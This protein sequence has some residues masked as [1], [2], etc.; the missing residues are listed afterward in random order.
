MKK[1]NAAIVCVTLALASPGWAGDGNLSPA[2]RSLVD[3]ER[4]F[5][6]R[7]GEVGVRASF[8]QFFADDAI[9]FSPE[10][11]R[12]KEA[13]KDL[14]PPADPLAVRLEWEPQEGSVASS[15]DLGYDT[16]PS[17]LTNKS[18][19]DKPKRFGQF[20]SVWKR[21]PDGSWKV[22]V[23]IGISTPA[24]A[25]PFGTPFHESAGAE[26]LRQ[27]EEESSSRPAQDP[28]MLDRQLTELS[29]SKGTLGAYLS[30]ASGEIRLLRDNHMPMVGTEGLRLYLSG[31]GASW[32]PVAGEI[33][34]AGDLGYTYGSYNSGP[35][36]SGN[37]EKGY[38]V[39]VCKRNVHGEWKLVADITNPVSPDQKK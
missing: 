23:D 6:K 17:V 19:T 27:R 39:H 9:A 8:L 22:A 5:A 3:T 30:Q 21:Q 4:S 2:L 25:S 7:C 34:H 32:S 13:V 35:V 29:A 26:D 20:L 24:E 36:D 12:Y 16:G 11:V 1:A 18:A 28:M 14:P 38:Y 33:S 10:P 15:A 37:V 31:E